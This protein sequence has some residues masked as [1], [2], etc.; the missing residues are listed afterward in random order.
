[1]YKLTPTLR[2]TLSAM[3]VALTILFLFAAATLPTG[4]LV[5]YLLASV[6]VFALTNEGMYLGAVLSFIATSAR[7]WLII[8]GK[9][10]VAPYIIILGHYCIFKDF[11]R[12]R[13]GDRVIG[14][15]LRLLYCNLFTGAGIAL[16]IYVFNL[17]LAALMPEMPLWLI[18]AVLEAGFICLDI[19][20]SLCR[21]IYINRIRNSRIK[22]K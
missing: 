15:A 21:T 14:F 10:S 13:I 18:V 3:T 22:R 17:D 11:L 5:C 16:A 4:R 6:F 9:L 1:M 2:I 19:L 7:A 12:N 20:T 8:P